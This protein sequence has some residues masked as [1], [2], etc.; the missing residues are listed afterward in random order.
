[1]SQRPA[2][3]DADGH[4][5]ERQSDV[6]K[7][8]RP[9]WD[10]R[11][12]SLLPTDQPWDSDLF[13]TL[14]RPHLRGLPPE[15]QLQ[16]WLEIM[17]REDFERAILF[18]T[19][20][21]SVV[22]LQER[23]F[24]AAVAAAFNDFV[25]NELNRRSDRVHAVGVLPLA[26]P[27]A[28]ARELNRAVDELGIRAFELVSAGLP[29][30]LGDPFYDPVWAEAE[31]L[32]PAMCIHGTR[33]HGYEVGA[34]KLRTF[35]EVH[36]YA[37]A[38]SLMLQFT[39]VVFGALPLRFP[40]LRLAFLEVGVSWLPYYLDRMDEHWEKRAEVETPLL[41]RKPSEVVR[42]AN[43]W[44]SIEAGETLLPQT[45][46]Y[47]G[48]RHFLYATDIPHWDNEF[49]ASLDRLWEHSGLSVATKQRILHDNALD[50]YALP[51]AA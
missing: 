4:Y 5:M 23:E 24:A 35:S 14:G 19:S 34:D 51:V 17:D 8:L 11:Q 20:F 22:K 6:A 45:I 50:L 28:A 49:P 30:A 38:A 43:I 41:T 32:G 3:I 31:R 37:F 29:L 42:Q 16:A 12:T 44:F 27:P 40:R 15:Q 33:T 46:D 48:D 13:G 18:P 47:L 1:M 39:S 25:A 26:D 9:P 10:R 36:C 7:Y 2:I 21:G